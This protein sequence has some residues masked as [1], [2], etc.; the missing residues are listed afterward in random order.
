[1]SATPA[2]AQTAPSPDQEHIAMRRHHPPS[3][4][5]LATLALVLSVILGLPGTALAAGPLPCDI[6]GG[7]GTPCVAAHSTVRALYAGYGGSLYRV[8]RASDGASADV[9]LLAT[10]GY[11][12]AAAQ[13]SFCATTSCVITVIYDQSPRHNDL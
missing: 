12:N 13:D 8:P 6:Y 5:V 3:V 11:A 4:A 2:A 10:G 9:G 1:M 7:A